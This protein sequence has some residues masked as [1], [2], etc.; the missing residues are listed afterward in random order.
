MRDHIIVFVFLFTAAG[1]SSA[2]NEYVIEEIIASFRYN[3][4]VL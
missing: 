4:G 1:Y 3:F 2:A